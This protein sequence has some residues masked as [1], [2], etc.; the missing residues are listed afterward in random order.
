MKRHTI[1][2]LL[3]L[4]LVFNGCGDKKKETTKKIDIK[5]VENSKEIKPLKPIF[6]NKYQVNEENTHEIYDKNDKENLQFFS[7]PKAYKDRKTGQILLK[8][9]KPNLDIKYRE[10]KE[11]NILGYFVCINEYGFASEEFH[12]YTFTVRLEKSSKVKLTKK[13]AIRLDLNEKKRYFINVYL[14]VN[15]YE[16]EKNPQ[17]KP[18]LSLCIYPG[19]EVEKTEIDY[20]E[21]DNLYPEIPIERLS[22]NELVVNNDKYR[23]RLF[24]LD[25]VLSGD[26][27]KR[28]LD[29][30]KVFISFSSSSELYIYDDS[31]AMQKHFSSAERYFVRKESINMKGLFPKL[32]GETKVKIYALGTYKYIFYNPLLVEVLK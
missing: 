19:V 4:G 27:P 12:Y 20:I 9:E 15:Y 29:D 31:G 23:N 22:L 13:R 11:E 32:K 2:W 18:V 24:E 26:V 7:K 6:E 10:I 8:W 1:F 21:D 30:K 3:I 28:L 14:I 5:Q 25:M 16:N 17:R